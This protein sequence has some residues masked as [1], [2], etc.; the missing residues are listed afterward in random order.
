MQDF[1]FQIANEKTIMNAENLDK[2][3]AHHL[4]GNIPVI[5]SG[6]FLSDRT[7]H[8]SREGWEDIDGWINLSIVQ[9]PVN[10]D[11]PLRNVACQIW[12]RMSNV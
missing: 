11:L 4:V 9:V 7:L 8:E 3:H 6:Q 5:L 10:N 1:R 12:N 2:E